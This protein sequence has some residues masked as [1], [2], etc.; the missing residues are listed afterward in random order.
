MAKFHFV[1]DY[2]IYVKSLLKSRPSKQAFEESVGGDFDVI[3]PIEAQIVQY[4]GLKDGM[5][6]VDFGCGSGRGAHFISKRVNI[7]YL[8]IDV[9]KELIDYAAQISPRHYRFAINHALTLPVTDRSV[10]MFC[11]FSVFTHLMHE[12][13]FLYLAEM[14]RA[15]KPQGR[16]VFSFLEFAQPGHWHV[17][18]ATAEMR[19]NNKHHPV[20]MFIERGSIE[21][22]CRHLE[23]KVSEFIDGPDGS[24]W[25]NGGSLGQSIAILDHA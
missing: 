7:D 13:S 9:V 21:T 24:R 4:A 2:K 22:W 6:L 1:D 11:A 12:E 5:L 8:G 23:L 3:G 20:N 17:F 14:K 18:K 15:L 19:R 25:E 10:D 16:I